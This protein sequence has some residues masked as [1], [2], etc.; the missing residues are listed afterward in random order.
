MDSVT[1]S[2][3]VLALIL[4]PWCFKTLFIIIKQKQQNIVCLLITSG[5]N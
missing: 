4:I 1:A 3:E 2:D 5:N